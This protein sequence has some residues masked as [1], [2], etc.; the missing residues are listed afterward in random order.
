MAADE[1]AAC[2]GYDSLMAVLLQETTLLVNLLQLFISSAA[3]RSPVRHHWA[4]CIGVLVA[5][6]VLL[7]LL[8]WEAKGVQIRHHRP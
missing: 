4:R 5:L 1:C 6:V 7:H 2:A 3:G 8:G